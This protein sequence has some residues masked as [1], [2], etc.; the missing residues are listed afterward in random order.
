MRRPDR[1]EW[2]P[3]LLAELRHHRRLAS[4]ARRAGVTLKAVRQA[5]IDD[6]HDLGHG[7]DE[8]LAAQI[9]AARRPLTLDER[10][11]RAEDEFAA[12]S[13]RTHMRMLIAERR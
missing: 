12:H 3:V 7:H 1:N 8:G 2:Q 4:A 9:A 11:R 6:A 5:I 10:Q 13:E